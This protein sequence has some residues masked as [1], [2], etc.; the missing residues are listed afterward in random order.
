MIII[1]SIYE[2]TLSDVAQISGQHWQENYAKI[3]C[4]LKMY[5]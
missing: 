3:L 5:V 4:L 2:L 1:F